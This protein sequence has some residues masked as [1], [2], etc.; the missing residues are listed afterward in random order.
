MAAIS[1]TTFSYACILIQIL[2][3]VVAQIKRQSVLETN[4]GRVYWHW[5]IWLRIYSISYCFSCQRISYINVIVA[6]YF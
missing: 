1:Q 4:D 6:S 3:N 2:L 5:V